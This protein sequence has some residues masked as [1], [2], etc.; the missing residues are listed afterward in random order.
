MKKSELRQVIREEI[1][2]LDERSGIGVMAKMKDAMETY[3]KNILMFQ[4]ML[5]E[6]NLDLKTQR[7]LKEMIDGENMQYKGLLQIMKS[8]K[9]Q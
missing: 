5:K 4:D 7:K 3:A 2:Q 9:R 8:I 1:G 6:P